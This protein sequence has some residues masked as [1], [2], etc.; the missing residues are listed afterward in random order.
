VKLRIRT[1]RWLV[2]AGFGV[3]LAACGG[4]SDAETGD[5]SSGGKSGASA[6]GSS[7]S[8]GSCVGK[9]TCFELCTCKGTPAATCLTQCQNQGTGGGGPNCGNGA[10]D[11]G[12]SCDGT[13]L[14]AENCATTTMGARPGGVLACSPSCTFDTNGCTGN[15]AGGA[16][17]SSGAGVGG[18]NGVGGAGGAGGFGGGAGGAGGFGGGAGGAGGFGG[19][20]GGAGGFGGG[21]P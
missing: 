12:E 15:G 19:G 16:G 13:N 21:G 6:G 8:S 1:N 7:G 2:L 11:P 10:L 3:I 5:D 18:S 17:G 20:A 4:S 14:G 9:T